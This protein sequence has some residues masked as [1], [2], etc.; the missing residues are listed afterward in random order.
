MDT[1]QISKKN[2]PNKHSNGL[3]IIGAFGLGL[4]I[5]LLNIISQGKIMTFSFPNVLDILMVIIILAII[6]LISIMRL[7]K[8]SRPGMFILD[9]D[10]SQKKK[11]FITYIIIDVVS[12]V[13][14]ILFIIYSLDNVFFILVNSIAL[15]LVIRNLATSQYQFYVDYFR[16]LRQNR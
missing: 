16:D 14:Y 11:I 12:L 10:T 8:T 5:L 4:F 13:A 7:R 15:F 3:Y 1:E 2:K 6:S 9:T